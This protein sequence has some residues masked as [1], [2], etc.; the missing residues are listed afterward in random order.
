ML[1]TPETAIEKL[2]LIYVNSDQLTIE[3][4]K[5]NEQFQ[6]L[7]NGQQ[8]QEGNRLQRI[9]Q[10]VIPPAW[11]EVKIA[12]LENAHLQATGK[13]LRRRKQYRYHPLWKQVRNQTKF[14]KMSVFGQQLPKIRRRVAKDLEQKGWPKTKVLALVIRLMEDTHIRVGNEQYAKRNKTYGLSTLRSKHVTALQDKIRF[15]FVGKRGKKHRITVKNKQL[16]RL[17]NRCE[18]LPGWE[19]FKFYDTDGKKKTIDSGMV[20]KYIHR[21]SGILF[22][23]KDFRTWAATVIFFERLMDMKSVKDKN[24]NMLMAYDETA[25]ALGNTRNVCRKY[26]VHPLAPSFYESGELEAYFKKVASD[27]EPAPELSQTETVVLDML[28]QYSP[29]FMGKL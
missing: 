6:Y 28:E 23:A 14:Y 20:N 10:L 3:R 7:L 1:Q 17:I 25:K 9:E 22:T 26:Y 29:S 12:S 21:I 2:D 4:I 15:E 5:Q 8:I 27:P 19:L 16:V 18:E 11:E 24:K 13:D